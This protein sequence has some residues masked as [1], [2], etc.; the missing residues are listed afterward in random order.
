MGGVSRTRFRSG[1]VVVGDARLPSGDVGAVWAKRARLRFPRMG[2][3]DA[4]VAV[5]AADGARGVTGGVA[6][7]TASNG[8]AGAPVGMGDVVARCFGGT[9][10]AASVAVAAARTAGFVFPDLTGVAA[11]FL[12][13]AEPVAFPAGTVPFPERST[14]PMAFPRRPAERATGAT[15][16]TRRCGSPFSVADERGTP[17]ARPAAA[18]AVAGLVGRTRSG[19]AIIDS[20]VVVAVV[21]RTSAGPTV[22]PPPMSAQ[23]RCVRQRTARICGLAKLISFVCLSFSLPSSAALSYYCR[24]THM[25]ETLRKGTKGRGRSACEHPPTLPGSQL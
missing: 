14:G 5:A 9:A 7:A 25:R 15:P 11:F 23:S 2:G 16:W 3:G 22:A 6:G 19:S 17:P 18:L 10:A 13:G 12:G 21:A 20:R 1:D 24:P 8:G 4:G